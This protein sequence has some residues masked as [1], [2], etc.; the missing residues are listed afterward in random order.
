MSLS[1]H[2]S[3]RTVRMHPPVIRK[4]AQMI[5]P[6]TISFGAGN[7]PAS[8]FPVDEIYAKTGEIL[9]KFG[10]RTMQYADTRGLPALR[11]WIANQT[12]SALSGPINS[13]RVTIISG[14]QQAI[15]L[16]G[17]LFVDEGD[18]VIVPAPTYASTLT[19]L[20]VYGA[21]YIGV[22][23]DE[24]G[25]LPD[26]LEEAC[27]QSPTLLYCIPNFS[28]PTGVYMSLER[29]QN[30]VKLAEK[31][32]IPIFED[33]PYG[34]LRFEGEALPNLYELA[35]DR[36]IYAGSFSKIVAPG[37]RIAWVVTPAEI[38]AKMVIAKQGTDL[39]SAYYTQFLLH[40]LVS[41][42]FIEPR[43]EQ[44]RTYYHNQCNL[45]L[46]AMKRHFPTEIVYHKP[47][48]G[49]FI[50][51]ELPAHLDATELLKPCFEEKV[52]YVPGAGFYP[53]N[54]PLLAKNTLRLS[55]SLATA[56]E[57]E[58]GIERLGRVFARAIRGT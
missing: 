52:A 36:V 55:F 45:M 9:E 11:Q 43:I 27:Q 38:T 23:C 58:V 8:V 41:D 7:P 14:S 47:Q 42:G 28:N 22:P 57:I 51:C 49:M 37:F 46:G 12:S 4:I 15:D 54:S 17:K 5:Q 44:L 1:K 13:D 56:E 48:G 3:Q 19:T 10:G 25:M 18:K 2:F 39:Q 20:N 30:I 21:D 31:Y 32:D 50:W 26:A 16:V 34:Y 24:Y 29:R 33:D 6:D 40:E 35:P 53:D